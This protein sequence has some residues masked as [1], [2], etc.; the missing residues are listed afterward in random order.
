MLM[1]LIVFAIGGKMYNTMLW[2]II[3]CGMYKFRVNIPQD[4]EQ[5]RIKKFNN[6]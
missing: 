3:V 5:K 6:F 2:V 1:S 4:D